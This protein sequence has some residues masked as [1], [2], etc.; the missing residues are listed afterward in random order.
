M[1]NVIGIIREGLSKKGE[2]R[3]AITPVYAK[4]IID[5]GHHLIVQPAVNPKTGEIKR[6]FPDILYKRAGAEINEDLSP[7]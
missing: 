1:K 3:V 2:K 5:W 4:Q 7:C 6:V